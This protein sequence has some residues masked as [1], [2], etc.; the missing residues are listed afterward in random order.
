[1]IFLKENYWP[2]SSKFQKIGIN[3][4]AHQRLLTVEGLR[5]EILNKLWCIHAMEHYLAIK[6]YL[7]LWKHDLHIVSLKQI[8]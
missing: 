3:L 5:V 2:Q 6:E 1:M 8:R 4:N 7:M